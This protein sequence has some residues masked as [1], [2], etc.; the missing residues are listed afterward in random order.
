[1]GLFDKFGKKHSD[2]FK[3][4]R[5]SVDDFRD[6]AAVLHFLLNGG[7]ADALKL[8]SELQG[9]Q[10]YVPALQM[11]IRPFVQKLEGNYVNLGFDMYSEK[12][13]KF[14]FESSTGTGKDT[15]SAVGQAVASFAFAFMAG[16]QRMFEQYQSRTAESTFAG[17]THKWNVYLSD[18]IAIGSKTKTQEANK[19]AAYWEL[20]HEDI[21]QRLGNQRLVYVKL[22]AAK[23]P[24][25]IVGECRI[26]DVPIPELGEKI[27]RIAEKWEVSGWASEKQFFFIEQSPETLL[28]YPYS[29]KAGREKMKSQ[30]I[31]YLR[32]FQAVDSQ[33]DYDRLPEDAKRLLEDEVLA[34]ECFSFLPEIL[35]ERIF[36]KN[37]TMKDA[38]E[39]SREDGTVI[40][41]YK[42]QL[43]DYAA[44]DR[45][46]FEIIQE[47]AFGEET[48]PLLLK[49][50]SYSA[51]SGIVE[52][53]REYKGDLSNLSVR[54]VFNVENDF[55]L[56]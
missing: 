46:T 31:E 9:D 4:K 6:E 35:A 15:R 47:A 29:G 54:M 7:I 36:A 22:F 8:Q 53:A 45:I 48:R 43:S 24:G 23:L 56:R 32:L 2:Q 44:L 17:N 19:V 37:V 12:W 30:V 16:M 20:L 50:A 1:M 28:S 33:E 25:Q 42:S 21:L 40:S 11:T 5:Q 27:A 39:I 52:Q 38:I 18:V 49:L 14:L 3:G 34:I 26:D 10:L 41:A 51:L 13:D 55:V